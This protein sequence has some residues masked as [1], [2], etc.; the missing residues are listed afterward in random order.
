MALVFLLVCLGI[1]TIV[2][3]FWKLLL[4]FLAHRGERLGASTGD[5]GKGM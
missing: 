4:A 3:T 2:S 1:F 5:A